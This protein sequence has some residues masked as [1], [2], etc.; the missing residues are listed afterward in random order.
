MFIGIGFITVPLIVLIYTRINRN[1]ARRMAKG[2]DKALTAD[3]LRSLGDRS[4]D[5]RYTL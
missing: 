5:F 4:P 3:E 2:E 1:K